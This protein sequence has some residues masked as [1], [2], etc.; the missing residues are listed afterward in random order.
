[1]RFGSVT[2]PS[3][4]AAGTRGTCWWV[5]GG[6]QPVDVGITAVGFVGASGWDSVGAVVGI[7]LAVGGSRPQ[8]APC[9]NKVYHPLLKPARLLS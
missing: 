2:R 1:M 7:A 9:L 8:Q 3:S 6:E 4:V 5:A